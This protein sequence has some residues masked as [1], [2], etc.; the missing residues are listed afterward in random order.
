[1]NNQP[2]F[3]LPF[4][5]AYFGETETCRHYVSRICDE[6][7]TADIDGFPGDEDTGSM[8]AWYILSMIG[9]YPICPADNTYVEISP[10]V[11]YEIKEK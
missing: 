3:V 9:K 4:I 7:F 5:F 8:A 6:M 2:G 11:E 1:M 10:L